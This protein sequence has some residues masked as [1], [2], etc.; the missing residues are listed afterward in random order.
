[1]VLNHAKR[2]CFGAVPQDAAI[3]GSELVWE[4]SYPALSGLAQFLSD[5]GD[6]LRLPAGTQTIGSQAF[7]DCTIGTVV[8]PASVTSVQWS[9]FDLF[10]GHTIILNM[11]S[12]QLPAG[13]RCPSEV[14]VIWKGSD[15]AA[16][17]P[18][19]PADAV[20]TSVL[21]RSAAQLT[22]PR[23]TAKIRSYALMECQSLT[24]IRIPRS[25]RKL[26]L[27][28]IWNCRILSDVTLEAGLK[29]IGMA[30]PACI[31]LRQMTIP[32]TVRTIHTSA[33]YDSGGIPVTLTVHRP[34]DSIAGA[35]WS[36]TGNVIWTAT[37]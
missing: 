10:A 17:E 32:S 15:P 19:G 6:I 22:I 23:G 5:T 2:V 24:Q 29:E 25:V 36:S 21:E 30:F 14:T 28:S 8:V 26:E 16:H 20:F 9:A 31:A 11:P 1:M 33:F 4:R 35:P 37:A 18:E 34:P 3:Q 12:S 7:R 27:C 13:I